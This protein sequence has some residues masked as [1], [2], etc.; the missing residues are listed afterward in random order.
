M[1]FT[2]EIKGGAELADL[3]D[4]MPDNVAN[5]IMLEAMR[6]GAKEIM[7]IAKS[8]APVGFEPLP[9]THD[10]GQLRDAIAVSRGAVTS[11]DQIVVRVGLDTSK[12]AFWGKFVEFGTHAST[13]K[14]KRP[15]HATKAYPFMRPAFDLGSQNA[16]DAITRYASGRIE[17]FS[18][19]SGIFLGGFDE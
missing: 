3:L 14:G 11:R 5:N 8:L 13:G 1:D 18:S 9:Q 4:K 10:S 6:A 19:D 16:I 2:L 7:E 15:H 12:K 17:Q